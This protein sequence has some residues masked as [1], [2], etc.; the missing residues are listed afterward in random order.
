MLKRL[1]SQAG[2]SLMQVMIAGALF[3][4]ISASILV[5]MYQNAKFK[6]TQDYR[7]GVLMARMNLVNQMNHS[8]SWY[9][10]IYDSDVN[11]TNPQIDCLRKIASQTGVDCT[12]AKGTL[13]IIDASGAEYYNPNKQES[14]FDR[15]GRP[16]NTYNTGNYTEMFNCPFRVDITWEAEC[17][18]NPCGSNPTIVIKASFS[19]ASHDDDQKIAFNPGN[20]YVEFRQ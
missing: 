18:S 19:M 9:K 10:T 4:G 11:G 13:R 1:Q 7:N 20:Y 3:A 5:S 16:C 14:G 6:H 17:L 8:L 2:Y 12:G 15:D